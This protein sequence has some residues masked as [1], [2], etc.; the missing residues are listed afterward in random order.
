[1]ETRESRH[2]GD[3]LYGIFPSTPNVGDRFVL[4]EGKLFIDDF[5]SVGL[6]HLSPEIIGDLTRTYCTKLMSKQLS[7]TLDRL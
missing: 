6:N 2:I 3:L 1:M 5:N 7:S 4:G